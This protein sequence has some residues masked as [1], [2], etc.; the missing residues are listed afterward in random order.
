MEFKANL[1]FPKEL[2]G[3]RVRQFRKEIGLTVEELAKRA[4]VSQ[5]MISQIERGQ[6]NPSLDTL[7]KL[8][9]YLEVPV[10]SFFKNIAPS[11][12]QITKRKDQKVMTMLHPNVTY[13][14]ISPT[15]DRRFELFEL[16]VQPGEVSHLPQLS[17]Q[18]EE[19]GFIIKGELELI[20]ED[21]TYYLETGDSIYFDS[22]MKHKFSNPG[23]EDAIGIW[24]M[25]PPD[26]QI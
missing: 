9:Y 4:G 13:R 11:E 17:H 25:I 6:T 3:K 10:F 8:S 5:S 7:W 12:V 20:I 15:L 21:K 2:I 18:G 16:I 1:E 22:R 19:I 26:P 14:L 23:N 24:L